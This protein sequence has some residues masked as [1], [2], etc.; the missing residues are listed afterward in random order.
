MTMR[1]IQESNTERNFNTLPSGKELGV[2]KVAN[3]SLYC[4]KFT[5]GG[6]LP[7]ELDGKW[8]D[9]Y[10]AQK[11]ITAY[12]AKKEVEKDTVVAKQA[13]EVVAKKTK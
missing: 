11:T 1:N 10:Q 8:T 3:S 7:A 2:F 13:P 12:L 6:Q 9:A 4:I 5:S